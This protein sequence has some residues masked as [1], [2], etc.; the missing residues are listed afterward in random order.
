MAVPLQPVVAV[1]V[2]IAVP[3]ATPVTMPVAMV[4]IVVLLLAHVAAAGT[5]VKNVVL[6]GH[7]DFVPVIFG[8]VFTV[9]VAICLHPALDV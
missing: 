3:A 9:T 4:A 1:A 6:P 8:L 2:M 7:M 5:L